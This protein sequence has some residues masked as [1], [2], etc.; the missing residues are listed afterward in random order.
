[1][2]WSATVDP[3]LRVGM[4]RA[5]GYVTGRDIF[6]ANEALYSDPAWQPGFDELWDCSDIS[7]F[8]VDLD[9][10]KDVAAM[11]VEGKDRVGNGRVAL[12]MTREVVQMVG[13]LY[14][15][16]VVE[17]E[18][19]V[20]VVQTLEAGAAWLGLDGVPDWLRAPGA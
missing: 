18:R 8:V 15:R 11:E 17:S 4:V 16:L 2:P 10:L 3:D 14:R 20:E 7:E 13:Y 5:T 1:M 12:V 6:L 9:E 19:P